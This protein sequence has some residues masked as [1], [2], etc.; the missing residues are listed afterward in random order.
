MYET[1][2]QKVVEEV[3][4]DIVDWCVTLWIEVWHCRLKGDIVYWS[5]TLWIGVWHCG[6]VCD[7]VDW[8]MTLWIGMWHCGLVCDIVDWCMTL[9]IGMWHCGLVCDIVDWCMTLWI[10]MWH[11]GLVCDIVDWCVTLWIGV[12]HCGLVCDIV[13]WCLISRASALAYENSITS[14]HP[15]ILHWITTGTLKN[16]FRSS[17]IIS[18]EAWYR[19]WLIDLQIPLVLSNS[20]CGGCLWFMDEALIGSIDPISWHRY[21]TMQYVIRLIIKVYRG[22]FLFMFLT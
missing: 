13:D 12:W 18:R 19:L 9:W 17:F 1:L 2:H 5:V 8:C 7:I 15:T 6:L 3:A 20:L 4:C 10:G 11:C 21:H 16:Y 22:R 14:F